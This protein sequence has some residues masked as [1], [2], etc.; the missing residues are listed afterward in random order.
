MNEA[1]N[2]LNS[3]QII[4]GLGAF[5][6]FSCELLLC[7]VECENNWQH[8]HT[9][10]EHTVRISFYYKTS[11][12]GTPMRA[13]TRRYRER[14]THSR[15]ASLAAKTFQVTTTKAVFTATFGICE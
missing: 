9:V 13:L 7:R 4:F 5:I 6:L 11:R 14:K 12:A 15:E 3:L 1:E 10:L 2:Y 8:M